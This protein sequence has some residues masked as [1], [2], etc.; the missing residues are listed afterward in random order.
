MSLGQN[1]GSSMALS[2]NKTALLALFLESILVCI[3]QSFDKAI[4]QAF[5]LNNVEAEE[6]PKLTFE[7][8]EKLDFDTFTRGWQR[9]VQAG[10]VT[11]DEGL[12][13]W[14]RQQWAAPE[15]DYTKTIK[16]TKTADP[17]ERVE[18]DKQK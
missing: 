10:A 6:L 9:L 14:I 11:T 3:Q 5:I 18:D 15:V 13:Q 8:V 16:N 17:I 4:K 1:I 2:D 12:E 7:E